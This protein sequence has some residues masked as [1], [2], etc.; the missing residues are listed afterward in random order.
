MR[1]REG[2][3]WSSRTYLIRLVLSWRQAEFSFFVGQMTEI[4]SE[5]IEREH[6]VR[7]LLFCVDGPKILKV[8]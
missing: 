3:L 1:L 4:A 6:I 5:A 7:Y 2:Q 8:L